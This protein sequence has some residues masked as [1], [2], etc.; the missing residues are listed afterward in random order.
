M[1]QRLSTPSSLRGD[2]DCNDDDDY[3]LA[4]RRS[5]ACGDVSFH[6]HPKGFTY[7]AGSFFFH[8]VEWGQQQEEDNFIHDS[9]IEKEKKKN[10]R[11]ESTLRLRAMELAELTRLYIVSATSNQ[12]LSMLVT[13]DAECCRGNAFAAR[14]AFANKAAA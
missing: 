8:G 12:F 2:H 6:I 13:L 4:R 3:A 10:K 9:Y 7:R 1:K 14:R 5:G 11:K